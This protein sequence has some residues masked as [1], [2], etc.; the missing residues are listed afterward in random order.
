MTTPILLSQYVDELKK[1]KPDSIMDK[2]LYTP[3]KSVITDG[4]RLYHVVCNPSELDSLSDW[5][6]SSNVITAAELIEELSVYLKTNPKTRLLSNGHYATRI[7]MVPALLFDPAY[8]HDNVEEKAFNEML[9]KA[10]NGEDLQTLLK[11]S[12]LNISCK[13]TKIGT[14]WHLGS[15]ASFKSSQIPSVPAWDLMDDLFHKVQ[16]KDCTLYIC[17]VPTDVYKE[18]I[19]PDDVKARV[20]KA[21]KTGPTIDAD[22]ALVKRINCCTNGYRITRYNEK[23]ERHGLSEH[24]VNG[25]LDTS[26]MYKNEVN[27]GENISYYPNG[28]KK[29]LA[30]VVRNS[31]MGPYFKWDENGNCT[32]KLNYVNSCPEGLQQLFYANGQLQEEYTCKSGNLHGTRRLWDENGKLTTEEEY[33]NGNLIVKTPTLQATSQPTRFFLEDKG[34]RLFVEKV[35]NLKILIGATSVSEKMP[36]DSAKLPDPLS[37]DRTLAKTHGISCIEQG[38]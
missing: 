9:Q 36:E 26:T 24:F 17:K 8:Q 27:E 31:W 19:K 2:P 30:T 4:G 7:V 20:D 28:Q 10:N 3:T 1:L 15:P 38:K 14:V 32:D 6:A 18:L 35:G 5:R 22:G 16:V 12:T 34:R 25:K 13:F 23:G 33:D 29:T 11:E 37:E 21:L